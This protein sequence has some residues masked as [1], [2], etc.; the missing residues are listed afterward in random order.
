[1]TIIH[2]LCIKSQWRNNSLIFELSVINIWREH[3][4]CPR[5]FVGIQSPQCF[6]EIIILP[7]CFRNTLVSGSCTMV[8]PKSFAISQEHRTQNNTRN[9]W[10][11]LSHTLSWPLCSNWTH[12]CIPPSNVVRPVIIFGDFSFLPTYDSALERHSYIDSW[13][14]GLL[15]CN[16]TEWELHI[17]SSSFPEHLSPFHSEPPAFSPFFHPQLCLHLFIPSLNLFLTHTHVA[18][19]P[20]VLYLCTAWKMIEVPIVLLFAWRLNS[21]LSIK[22]LHK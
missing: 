7:N 5:L 3:L 10:T 4:A 6:Y 17:N 13:M 21:I 1:M 14:Y 19:Y 11:F 9:G 2:I 16:A 15:F 18:L 12:P 20:A 8:S 22:R